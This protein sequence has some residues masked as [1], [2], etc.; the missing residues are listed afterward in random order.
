MAATGCL[1]SRELPIKKE[2]IVRQ[3][4]EVTTGQSQ[5]GANHHN[6]GFL[7]NNDTHISQRL[8]FTQ[9]EHH[10]LSGVSGHPHKMLVVFVLDRKIVEQNNEGL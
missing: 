2:R 6:P 4:T 1:S 9:Q 10:K 8:K 3:N 7:P 5:N